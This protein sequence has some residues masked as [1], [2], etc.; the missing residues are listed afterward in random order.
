MKI[1]LIPLV[2]LSL[3]ACSSVTTHDTFIESTFELCGGSVDTY[4]ASD[5]KV[6]I[7]CEDKSSFAI[8]STDTLDI[9]RNINADYCGGSG[10]GSFNEST[11]YYLFRCK[12][13][14]TVSIPKK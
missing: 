7:V 11:K 1:L 4:S 5:D 9:M 2:A 6:R 8:N 10:L 12:E 14:A 3:T 13:G